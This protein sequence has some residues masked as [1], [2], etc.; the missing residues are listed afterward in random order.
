MSQKAPVIP[1]RSIIKI[2]MNW[3]MSMTT[4]S[5]MKSREENLSKSLR[6]KYDMKQRAI[7]VTEPKYLKKV[8]PPVILVLDTRISMDIKRLLMP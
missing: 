5:K 7:A 4:F 6:K 8:P 3:I 1:T 2:M